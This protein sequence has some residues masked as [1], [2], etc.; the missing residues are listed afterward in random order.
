MKQRIRQRTPFPTTNEAL[1]I[2]IHEELDAITSE[3]LS[4]LVNSLPT[5]VREVYIILFLLSSRL[6]ALSAYYLNY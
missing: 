5:R 6:R 1:H 4:S 3:E 2:A